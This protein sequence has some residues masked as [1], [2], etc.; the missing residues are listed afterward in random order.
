MSGYSREE[1]LSMT[2]KDPD[3]IEI[4]EETTVRIKR[5]FENGSELFQPCHRRK[6]GTLLPLEISVTLLPENGGQ[7]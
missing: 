4:P 2:I 7:G 5:I 1:L 3:A 6:D